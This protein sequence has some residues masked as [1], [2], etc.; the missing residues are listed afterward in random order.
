M[1]FFYVDRLVRDHAFF[2]SAAWGQDCHAID[3]TKPLNGFSMC[4]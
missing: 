4:R 3:E 1:P 2:S